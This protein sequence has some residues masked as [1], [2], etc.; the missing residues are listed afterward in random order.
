[1][2]EFEEGT[3]EIS[4]GNQIKIYRAGQ[5]TEI[6]EA[7]SIER[8]AHG[9]LFDEFIDW[10]DGGKPSATQISDNIKS[11]IMVIA[12]METTDDGSPKQLAEYLKDL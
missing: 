5:E 3:A 10:L 9:H 8:L 6:Y 2:V 4:S 11:F 1:M 7:P 12:A